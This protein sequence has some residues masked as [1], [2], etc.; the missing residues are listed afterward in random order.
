MPQNRLLLAPTCNK[1]RSFVSSKNSNGNFALSPLTRSGLII[2]INEYPLFARPH[3]NSV[4]CSFVR[5]ATLPK[6]TYTTGRAFFSSSHSKQS[7]CSFHRF[8]LRS[9][10]GLTGTCSNSIAVVQLYKLVVKLRP[11]QSKLLVQARRMYL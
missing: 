1:P 9:L 10:I 7:G 4:N 8:K 2:H 11:L 6:F 3:A 5:V